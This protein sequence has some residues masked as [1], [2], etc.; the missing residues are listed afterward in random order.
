MGRGIRLAALTIL[1]AALGLA[2]TARASISAS[3]TISEQQLGP[4]S[5]QYSLTLTNSATSTDPISTFW[6]AWFPGY[7]LLHSNPTAFTAPTG[8]NG[9]NAPDS[10]GVASA[11][12]TTSTESLAP[13]STLGGFSFTTPDAPSAIIGATSPYFGIP[14]EETYVYSGPPE[15]GSDAVFVPTTVPEPASIALLA[16]GA[17][18]LLLR[19]RGV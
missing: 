4:S 1:A 2:T 9:I 5:Y 18:G 12:Y 16:V 11:Q 6:F 19:R 15:T 10:N 14:V 17:T 13:G 8:W 3:A 7:D